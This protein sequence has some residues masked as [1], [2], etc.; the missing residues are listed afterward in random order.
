[1]KRIFLAGMLSAVLVF[2]FAG[3]GSGGRESDNDIAYGRVITTD[4]TSIQVELGNYDKEKGFTGSNREAVY[5]L[6]ES[7]FYTDFKKG[8]LVTLILDGKDATVVMTAEEM[9]ASSDASAETASKT[10]SYESAEALLVSDGTENVENSKTYVSGE[11][12]KKCVLVKNRGDLILNSSNLTSSSEDSQAVLVTGYRSAILAENININTSGDGSQGFLAVAS[13]E[14]TA[15][16]VTLRTTGDG[17]PP[18]QAGKGSVIDVSEG[19][20][21][22]AGA[23]SPGIFSAG[24]IS[25]TDSSA[26][27][28]ESEGSVIEPGG[29]FTLKTSRLTAASESGIVFRSGDGSG[30]GSAA[31]K[32]TATG[33]SMVSGGAAAMFRVEGMRGVVNLINTNLT[34]ASGVLADVAV[35]SG[36]DESGSSAGTDAADEDGV[37]SSDAAAKLILSGCHQEFS[38]EIRCGRR[39][40]VKLVLTEESSFRGAIDRTNTA[41]YS[42]IFLSKDSTW[43]VTAD[44]YVD[45]VVNKKKDC[46]NITSQGYTVYYNGDNKANQWLKGRTI[47][48][49][50]GGKLMPM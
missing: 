27:A 24:K 11:A 15:Q 45:A 12:G 40:Q 14:V 44:S 42:K 5:D 7:V 43:E 46:S 10:S 49:E 21:N 28:E 31:G 36:D 18:L 33:S 6:P 32:F 17:S 39:G 9:A 30:S 35:E 41:G 25:L 8:D 22:S 4:E 3:C 16:Q 38:G 29:S 19:V 26:I 37:V 50:G 47:Q 1:M 2:L 13:G 20:L 48:L 34:T 23:S